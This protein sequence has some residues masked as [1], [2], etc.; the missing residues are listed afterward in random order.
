MIRTSLR[1]YYVLGSL[2]ALLLVI[3]AGAGVFTEGLYSPFL[4][5]ELVAFQ[6]FQDLVSLL[7]APLLIAAMVYRRAR[8]S[9]GVHHLG[10]AAGVR[11]VL[12]RFLRVWHGVHGL[13]SALP[14]L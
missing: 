1:P 13:L 8:L 9:A 2:I 10:R 6:Y 11:A 5:A 7:F 3:T 14:W 4:S 12:L